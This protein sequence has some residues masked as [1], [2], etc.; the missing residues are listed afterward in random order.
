ML[1]KNLFLFIL[2]GFLFCCFIGCSNIETAPSY[3]YGK[4]R[5][6]SDDPN[7]Q[8]FISEENTYLEIKKDQ[9]I[10]YNSTINNKPKF[11]FSGDF[12]FDKTTNTLTIK[13]KDGKLPSDL[14]IEKSNNDYL[15]RIGETNYKKEIK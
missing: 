1:H 10:E 2:S 9:T 5:I 6:S 14:K 4:Y 11:N 8:R 3:V 15:I 7:V 12:T 13:W